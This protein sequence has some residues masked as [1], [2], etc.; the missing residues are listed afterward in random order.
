[1]VKNIALF[2]SKNRTKLYL[3]PDVNKKWLTVAQATGF[4]GAGGGGVLGV[5]EAI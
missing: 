4:F 5:L 3:I 1:M 2:L